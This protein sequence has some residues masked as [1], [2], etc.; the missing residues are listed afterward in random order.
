MAVQRNP[1][2]Q[3]LRL[4]A[5]EAYL[6]A[7]ETH[8]ALEVGRHR[9]HPHHDA[10]QKAV[11]NIKD[12][13][14]IVMDDQFKE[15]G[16]KISNTRP[17]S[18]HRGEFFVDSGNV[19]E[20]ER[21]PRYQ[22]ERSTQPQVANTSRSR[23]KQSPNGPQV[24]ETQAPHVKPVAVPATKQCPTHK[25][26][27]P[28]SSFSQPVLGRATTRSCSSNMETRMPLQ[29]RSMN[30]NISSK[31]VP[32][33]PKQEPSR[34]SR[35][36]SDCQ[37]SNYSDTTHEIVYIPNSASTQA[38]M[39]CTGCGWNAIYSG[40]P[41]ICI[42]GWDAKMVCLYCICSKFHSGGHDFY[43]ADCHNEYDARGRR[44]TSIEAMNEHA[45][46]HSAKR[47]KARNCSHPECNPKKSMKSKRK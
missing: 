21:I 3:Q 44:F 19:V 29:H 5:M 32:P 39:E 20:R 16:Y 9:V 6:W 36:T 18:R 17:R 25:V 41:R 2:L 38:R 26:P 30:E 12:S 10:I 22:G 43:C 14:R 37:R 1:R 33:L 34:V 4:T 45:T 11:S 31:K 23:N 46:H 13:F 8:R 15:L 7:A 40:D 42:V 47:I 28:P 35:E 24:P 27:A